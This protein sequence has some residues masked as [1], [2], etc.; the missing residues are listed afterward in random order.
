MVEYGRPGDFRI[1][2]ARPRQRGP[3]PG[4]VLV[5][6]RNDGLILG[7]D[8]C[9][10]AGAQAVADVARLVILDQQARPQIRIPGCERTGRCPLG[11]QTE[12]HYHAPPEC[13]CHCGPPNLL[14]TC[15][16]FWLQRVLLCEG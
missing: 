8:G 9:V 2:P 5:Q 11:E 10:L 15:A 13:E 14:D 3:V 6:R 16:V 7:Q 4:S 1:V 12:C